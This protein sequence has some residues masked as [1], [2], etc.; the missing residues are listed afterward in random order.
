MPRKSKAVAEYE[1]AVKEKAPPKEEPKPSNPNEFVCGKITLQVNKSKGDYVPADLPYVPEQKDMELVAYAIQENMPVL[2]IGETGTGKTSL[3]RHLAAKTN[4]NF[5][6]LNLNGAT[7]VDEF[8]GKMLLNENGTY[9]VNGILIDAMI[10]GHWLLLDEINAAL[11]EILFV[12]HSLLDDDRY[13]VVAE[14]NNEK[15]HPHP[16]FR[17]FATMNPSDTYAG[18]KELNKAFLSRF[19]MTIKVGFPDA[20]RETEILVKKTG[21]IE[22]IARQL[23]TLGGSLRKSYEQEKLSFVCSTR[24]LVNIASMLDN[25]DIKDA[26]QVVLLN[27][28]NPE[29]RNAVKDL[30][31]L[32][33]GKFN[34]DADKGNL[35]TFVKESE[36]K[37]MKKDNDTLYEQNGKL[38]SEN[39]KLKR[40]MSK[41][42]SSFTD[43]KNTLDEY[44][45]KIE[46]FLT[47]A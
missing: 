6:R 7:T 10:N 4:N 3:I 35:F 5:R 27:K 30:I 38:K 45:A 44:K 26:C 1:E 12:L 34:D 18:T 25:V 40:A 32:H 36:L 19:P 39:D 13:V 22:T 47:G 15:V 21:V 43:T 17:I 16:N 9:W 2:L 14:N 46:E 42:D 23:V 8:V 33:F 29:D 37:Q 41:V 31:Q 28:T 11:P 24:E 20:E